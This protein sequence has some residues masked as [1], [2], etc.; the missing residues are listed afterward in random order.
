MRLLP[1]GVLLPDEHDDMAVLRASPVM[2]KG[3]AA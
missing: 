3:L 2:L 1:H